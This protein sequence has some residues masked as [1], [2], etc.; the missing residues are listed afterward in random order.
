M[1]Q[2]IKIDPLTR[3]EGHARISI[4]LN[5]AGQ[6]NDAQLHVTQLRGFE[7]LAQGRPFRE[8][9]A[10]TARICGICP[11]SHL[12]ASAKACDELLGVSIPETAVMLRRLVNY[13]QMVQ[14]HALSFFYLS[15]P[16]LL[17]GMDAPVAERNIAG[18][19]KTAPALARDGIRLRQFGQQLIEGLGGKRIHNAWLIGG[20]V[21]EPLKAEIQEDALAKIPEMLGIIEGTI[22][23]FRA[24][25]PHFAAEIEAF[26]NFPTMYMGLVSAQNSLEYYDGQLRLVNENGETVSDIDRKAYADKIGEAVESFSYLKSPYYLPMGYPAGIYRVGALARLQ[27]VKSCGTALADAELARFRSIPKSERQSSFYYHYARLIEILHGLERI[28]ALLNEPEILST[29]IRV[30]GEVLNQEGIGIIEAPRG[31]LI[32]H[33]KIDKNGLI[34]D[35]NLIVS[36]GH[37]VLAMNRGIKQAAQKFVDA[38]KLEEGMLNRVEAVIRAFDPCLSCATH[39]VG[40]MPLHIQVLAV[41]G[42]LVKE[43]KR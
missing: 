20:G 9:P 8:M 1:S 12:L 26:A 2:I 30:H 35:M 25:L 27:V 24:I 33:Y 40:Q 41:D 39:A 3:I 21:T 23:Q 19:A 28:K 16:D 37:N 11:V 34:T 29:D 31:T 7:K 17:L 4:Y 6:V 14:S 36:T 13:A 38:G 32:H 43:V 42:S 15:A 18:L 5:E 10:L 22:E